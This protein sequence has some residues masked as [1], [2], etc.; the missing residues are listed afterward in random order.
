M[1]TYLAVNIAK[2][3]FQVGST[4]D[5]PRRQRSHL[6]DENTIPFL[7]DL[8]RNPEEFFWFVSP[9]DGLNDRSEE[10]YYLDFYTGSPWCYNLNPNAEA[11][12]NLSGHKFREETLE[13]RSQSRQGKNYGVV[14]ENHPMFGKS[15]TEDSIEANRQSHLDRFWVNNG[16]DEKFLP[17]GSEIPD[18]YSP[19]R[20]F[21]LGK[22]KWWSNGKTVTRAAE[23]P[24]EGWVNS[25]KVNP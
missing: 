4:Q 19:G 15:H 23:C 8:R 10:Q 6:R 11:P 20:L 2:K 16:V 1:Y 24:G 25:R 17:P 3:K 7:N 18:G 14:G 21:I 12:P 22:L 9:D 5:F 13:K